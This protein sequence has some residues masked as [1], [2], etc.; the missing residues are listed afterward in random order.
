MLHKMR[1][2]PSFIHLELAF[3]Q[4]SFKNTKIFIAAT[5]Q[6]STM[7]DQWETILLC[8]AIFTS[9]GQVGS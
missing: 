8:T 3:K 1:R 2:F 4:L 5:A 7:S 6:L 9:I